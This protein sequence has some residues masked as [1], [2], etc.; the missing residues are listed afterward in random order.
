[1][2]R[3]NVNESSTSG[4]APLSGTSHA[5]RNDGEPSTRSD[6]QYLETIQQHEAAEGALVANGGAGDSDLCRRL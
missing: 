5:A 4:P 3:I 2:S 6:S 1:M